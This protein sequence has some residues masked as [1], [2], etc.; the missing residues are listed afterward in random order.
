MTN[1]T[2]RKKV[3]S[4]TK[5]FGILLRKFYSVDSDILYLL[6]NSFCASFYGS[7]LCINFR[8][9][10]SFRHISVSYHNALK[11][12]LGLHKFYN[13]HFVY[14]IFNTLT[15][16]LFKFFWRTKF[17]SCMAGKM[18]YSPFFTYI[19]HILQDILTL[20]RKLI[21]C[22]NANMEWWNF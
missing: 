22:G 2:L 1:W 15:F 10:R 5:S 16:E 19:N 21:M 3:E 14:S 6:F 7:E 12:I 13:N 18:Q 9:H 8:I 11:K 4:F 17:I 20:Y